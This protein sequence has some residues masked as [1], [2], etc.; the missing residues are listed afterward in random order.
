MSRTLAAALA[1]ALS[2]GACMYDSGTTEGAL[3]SAGVADV[4]APA[5]RAQVGD[6]PRTVVIDPPLGHLILSADV[7]CGDQWAR[8]NV[9]TALPADELEVRAQLEMKPGPY[10][11][12][13]P[14]RTSWPAQPL[15]R[16]PGARTYPYA[17]DLPLDG[18]TC[19][20]LKAQLGD[21]HGAFGGNLGSF[22]FQPAP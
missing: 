12:W 17:A 1:A 2:L 7:V 6:G 3:T 13:Y 19:D 10:G 9:E 20:D 14:V 11:R 4:A 18:L 15:L 5:D 16:A 21:V 22:V 8:V